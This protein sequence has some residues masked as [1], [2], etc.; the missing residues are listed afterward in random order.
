MPAPK[1]VQPLPLTLIFRSAL[2]R[3]RTDNRFVN[4]RRVVNQ[5]EDESG[6]K[7]EG[8]P[9]P[10][11]IRQR[12]FHANDLALARHPETRKWGVVRVLE[13]LSSGRCVRERDLHKTHQRK[14]RA[15]DTFLLDGFFQRVSF[16]DSVGTVG[17]CFLVFLTALVRVWEFPI[18]EPL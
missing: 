10:R 5:D 7:T 17:E 16:L 9:P 1:Q 13:A 8:R 14:Q 3:P 6:H 2:L 18:R 12:R 15:Q 11:A 4:L